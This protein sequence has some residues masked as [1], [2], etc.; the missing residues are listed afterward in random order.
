[1]VAPA[2]GAGKVDSYMQEEITKYRGPIQQGARDY[3]VSANRVMMAASQLIRALQQATCNM[4]HEMAE[5][6]LEPARNGATPETQER[7]YLIALAS[8]PTTAHMQAIESTSFVDGEGEGLD[9]LRDIIA[10][11]MAN[12]LQADSTL[13]KL[14]DAFSSATRTE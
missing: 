13:A 8:Y 3:I 2:M 14:H 7:N 4:S 9:K 11:E 12:V 10:D 6:P 1:M 5:H